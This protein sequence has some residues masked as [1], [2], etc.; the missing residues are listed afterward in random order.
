[1]FYLIGDAVDHRD[2][3]IYAAW[4]CAAVSRY[5]PKDIAADWACVAQGS[6]IRATL[7]R[8]F[9]AL[10]TVARE[11]SAPDTVT[12]DPVDAIAHKVD[13]VGDMRCIHDR[14]RCT[15]VD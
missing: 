8:I 2:L 14:L 6:E 7:I 11:R 4:G 15:A 10:T 1:M 5:H 3:S 13:I 12:I 9:G